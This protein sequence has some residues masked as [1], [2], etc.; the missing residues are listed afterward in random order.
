MID[1][2]VGS[3][4][5]RV[6]YQN[7]KNLDKLMNGDLPFYP[8]RLGL[9]KQSWAGMQAEF[10][11][12]QEGRLASFNSF[13]KS[14]GY[15][16]LGTYKAGI[17]ITAYNQYVMY[18][19]QPY[20]L[21]GSSRVPYT[22]TGD[23]AT[24]STSF[25]LL[26]DDT[27]RQDLSNA[28]DPA[29]GSAL[30][31]SVGRVVGSIA[32]I[33]SLPK[34][35]SQTAFALAFA[36]K[37]DLG[38]GNYYLDTTDTTSL[39]NGGTILV[40]GDGG[41][42]KLVHNGTIS[43][44]VFGAGR[45]GD[46]TAA[47]KAACGLGLRVHAPAG[48]YLIT[49]NVPVSWE[50]FGDGKNSTTITV[51][52]SG[53]DVFTFSGDYTGAYGFT[54]TSN[55]QRT[56]GITFNV[57]AATRGNQ[58]K[59]IRTQ[60]QFLSYKISGNAVQTYMLRLEILDATATTGGGIFIDGGNDTFLENVV[61][62]ASGTQPRYGLR[63]Q[64][65]QAIWVYACDFL[66]AQV[67]LLI[68]PTTGDLI[69]WLFFDECAFDQGSAN[70]IE[71]NVSGTGSLRGVFFS[72]CWS[73]TNNRGVYISK[74]S[75][76]QLDLVVFEGQKLLNNSLQGALIAGGDNI[77]FDGGIVSGNSLAQYGN[78]AGIDFQSGVSGFSV[79][80]VRVGAVA[81]FSNIQSYGVLIGTNCNGYQI[82]E[83]NLTGNQ[84]SGL[85]DNSYTTSTERIVTGNL[86]AKTRVSGTA[87]IPA[88]KSSFSVIHGLNGIPTS[89]IV[90]PTANLGTLTYW[91]ANPSSTGFDIK[92][93]Y[94]V[95]ADTSF[96]WTAS[97]Y[98]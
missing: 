20:R 57:S 72:G 56:G 13:L 23:W 60:N 5:P 47:F 94:N 9:L 32:A 33:R 8:S 28:V 85:A 11:A 51:N 93:S 12:A 46:D 3:S 58:F 48:N 54:V 77:I 37:G 89:A 86:G 64:N 52:G 24:E 25:V 53:F 63:V 16:D 81:G 68:D 43:V 31:P 90:T 92:T 15:Q 44:R 55:T 2:T 95:S 21:A 59:D 45:G 18:N 88:G 73:A 65:S 78:Y 36:S 34:T 98:D 75:G 83:C 22:T 6:L 87:T 40:A 80:G 1:L 84:T 96:Y 14:S 82:V 27:L 70:G 74:A 62:D 76:A 50:L 35:G 97:I 4:D 49:G 67:P 91:T 39:D 66:H 61:F 38:G 7:A 10:K 41:R 79:R 17:Q 19:G 29:K 71:I 26:G 42:W 69:T 30:I